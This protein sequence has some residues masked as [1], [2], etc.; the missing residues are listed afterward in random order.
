MAK[1]TTTRTRPA[2]TSKGSQQARLERIRTMVTKL[3]EPVKIYKVKDLLDDDAHMVTRIEYRGKVTEVRFL[4]AVERTLF[5]LI[6]GEMDAPA[7]A[8]R[9]RKAATRR[10]VK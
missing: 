1:K 9:A 6:V 5:E 2:G 7:A 10:K 4:E 3:P 8:P